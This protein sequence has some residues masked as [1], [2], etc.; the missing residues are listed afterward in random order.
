MTRSPKHVGL[1]RRRGSLSAL[2]F[3]RIACNGVRPPGLLYQTRAKKTK[4]S[5]R[6]R[7]Q[8][9]R[10]RFSC[11]FFVDYVIYAWV[12]NLGYQRATIGFLYRE[13]GN[14]RTTIVVCDVVF[15]FLAYC[16]PPPA[17]LPPC[18]LCLRACVYGW[19]CGQLA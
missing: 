10:G 6:C 5:S 13:F 16:V 1:A 4:S 11:F 7:V 19:E 17:V 3:P 8:N 9:S 2:H 15:G 14:W 18:S 12:G